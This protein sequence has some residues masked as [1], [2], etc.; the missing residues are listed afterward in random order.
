MPA[1]IK[2][3]KDE[4]RWSKAKSAV[5]QSHNKGEEAFT[6]QDWALANHIYHKMQKADL[7]NSLLEITELSKNT[8]DNQSLDQLKIGRAHVWTPVT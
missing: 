3:K 5:S 8:S 1:F 6:D 4:K 7:E 2:D